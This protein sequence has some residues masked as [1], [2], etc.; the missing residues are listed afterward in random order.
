MRG[1]ELLDLHYTGPFDELP[2][3]RGVVHRVIPWTEVSQ[4]E[5][6]GIVHIAPGC[7]EEDFALGKEFGLPAIAPIDESGVFVGG[8]DW[9]V[10]LTTEEAARPIADNLR[11]K[12][13]L[14]RAEP[15]RHRYPHCWRCGTQLV[16]RLVDEWFISMNELREPLMDITRQIRWIPDFGLERELDWLRNMHDWMI[17]KKR[18]WGLALPTW[19]CADCQRFEVV[20]SREELRERAVEGWEAFEGHS[21]HRPWID[22]IKLAC[23]QCGRPISRVADVGN[24]WLDAGIVAYSTLGYRANHAYWEKWFPAD[25][26]TE[27]FPGQYRNWFYAMLVMSTVLENRPPF[28]TVLGH[29]TIR[30]EQGRP[31]HKS[32]GNSIAFDEAAERAG[33]DVLRWIFSQHNP[34]ANLNFGWKTADE[35]KRR[36]LK[37][38]DSYYFFVLYAR[39]EGWRPGDGADAPRSQ[40]D[41]WL[42]ARL[43]ALIRTVCGRLDDVDAMAASRAIEDFFDELSNWYIRRSRARFWSPGG[44]ADPAALATLHEALV[45]LARLLAP[46][47]PFLAEELY[48]NLVRSIDAAAPTSVHH[49]DYP[50]PDPALEDP[51]LVE[52]VEWTRLVASLGNAA[53]KS[54]GIRVRQPLPAVRVAGGSTFDQLPSWA[55][56]LIK[57]ELNVKY[58]EFARELSEA[59][60]R[61]VEPNVKVLAPKYR[62][63]YPAIRDALRAGQFTVLADG[64]VE[65]AGVTLDA[66]EAAV[67]LEPAPGYAAAADRGV[68]VVLDTTLTPELVAQGNAREIVRLIQDA[69]KRAGFDVSDRI[70][71]R[72]QADGLAEVFKQHAKYICRE[73]LATGLDELGDADGW[74]RAEDQIDGVPVVV[75]VRRS[76]G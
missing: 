24:P 69:R 18:Y 59:V 71:V 49:T 51:E 1:A 60:R 32:L 20:G 40:L 12:G 73:T 67:S 64:R 53:R 29:G 44:R 66:D 21:P 47:M 8:F 38:W 33:A 3:Q 74:Y 31:M 48:Q 46:F 6:T 42:Q 57:D 62:S 27:S 17:S 28:R 61:R 5:G 10:G 39:P 75:A 68:L 43:Q 25:F 16:F 34:A 52:Q 35:T 76:A 23:S 37:L 2:A 11:E 14:F 19:E 36:L 45:T 30:D 65:V 15:Y 58:V 63:Q 70:E 4:E 54:A 72:Y 56:P 41:R 13:L 7:G 50:A 55:V 22:A 9:L 26:I